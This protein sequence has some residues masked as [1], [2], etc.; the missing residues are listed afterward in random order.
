MKKIFAVI[1]LITLGLATATPAIGQ[2]AQR[3]D[4]G[5]PGKQGPWPVTLSGGTPT[6][7][8]FAFQSPATVMKVTN[9]NVL[10]S[11]STSLGTPAT[12]RLGVLIKN[13]GPNSIWCVN[14]TATVGSG[15][16]VSGGQA[17]YL[18]ISAAVTVQC[19]AATADQVNGANT[20]V[21]E[22]SSS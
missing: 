17:I 20:S 9:V 7:A 11:A 10:N 22:L 12:N 8:I 21:T 5:Q 15:V 16:E 13:S 6:T 14:G 3:V 19:R 4:Q 2:S 1:G 18:A